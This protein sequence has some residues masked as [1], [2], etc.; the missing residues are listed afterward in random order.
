ML[1]FDLIAH[2]LMFS[3]CILAYIQYLLCYVMLCYVMLCYVMLCYVMLC[4]VMLWKY[5]RKN[6]DESEWLIC[7]I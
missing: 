1:G 4:Y 3:T 5:F 7:E 6:T 2:G